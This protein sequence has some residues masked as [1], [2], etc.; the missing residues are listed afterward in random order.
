MAENTIANRTLFIADNLD[1]LRGMNSA[2]VDLIYLDPP[3]NSGK[4]WRAPV[5]SIA[6]GA[7]FKD[8]WTLDD[9]KEEWVD[10]I[11]ERNPAL[12]YTIR[13][14]GFSSG[15][16]MQGYLT[17]MAVRLL[18]MRR[19]LK[20]T[21][22]IYLHC[23]DTAS[24]HLRNVLDSVFGAANFRNVITWKRT[25]AHNDSRRFGRVADMILFYGGTDINADA[26]RSS[27]G[28]D[29]VRRFYRHEDERGV[30]RVGDLTAAGA[31]GGESGQAWRGV[32]PTRVERHW[33]VPITGEYAEWID[34]N[35]I[36]GYLDIEGVMDRLD[37][38]DAAN[39]IA[40]PKKD[41]GVPQLK[42]Y[43]DSSVGQVPT[44]IWNDI[45]PVH[46]RSKERTGYPTQ[47]PIAL[48]ERIIRASS[49]EGGLVLD[50]F[51]GCATT[52]VAAE[53]LGRQWI[54]VDLSE[55]AY[56][57]VVERLAKEVQIAS[58]DLRGARR[59]FSGFVGDVTR[60]MDAPKRTDLPPAA[61][62]AR[63]SAN[64]RPALYAAQGGKCNGCEWPMPIHVLT[65][66][67]V[68]P[69]SADGPDID[70]N[71]QLLC[72]NCNS[73][74]NSRIIPIEQLREETKARGTHISV[75]GGG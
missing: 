65:I 57:L 20:P 22:S 50:P 37:A 46:A 29:Y 6:A 40:W 7:A 67:H 28:K 27:L 26:V 13:A 21:G 4:Q 61:A 39:L 36:P 64:I 47:K 42:R 35:V 60:R 15:P 55:K 16:R 14:A 25:S 62:G 70:A 1:V 58:G 63:R 49:N 23:D 31:A 51:C 12:H 5:G 54:G 2:T 48:L 68:H 24:H 75:S 19:V 72:G 44:V 38:L 73:V 53:K 69:T 74:K 33:A 43:I 34:E 11:E 52:C 9:V 66:D 3:F 32:D 59:P 30:Y 41:D 8:A 18:E 10:E 71:L 56:D 45:K 17:Y